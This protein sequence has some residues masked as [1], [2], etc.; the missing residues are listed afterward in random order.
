MSKLSIAKQIPIQ[1]L[2]KRILKKVLSAKRIDYTAKECRNASSKYRLISLLDDTE[3]D[4]TSNSVA[5]NH[6][7]KHEFNLLGSGWLNRNAKKEIELHSK[8][9]DFYKKT[10]KYISDNYQFINWQL[11]I[12]SG[13]EFDVAKQF[14]KQKPD[15]T[16]CIDVKNCWELGRLQHFLQMAFASKGAKNKEE[17]ILEFKNQCLDFIA[18]NPVGMGIQWACT[19]DVGIRVANL[20]LA[21]DFFNEIDETDI[22]DDQFNQMF[23]NSIYQH[24]L[25]IYHHLEKKEGAAGN[26][27]LFNLIG[28]LFVSN[29]L[30]ESE[31]IEQ[32]RILAEYELENE[33][34]K[35]FLNDGGNFEGS[36]TYHCLSTEAMMY[37]TVFMLRNDKKLDQ[38]YIDLLVKA[39]KFIVDVMKP[40]GEMP[41]FGD[42][43]SGRLFIFYQDQD[44]K[45]NLLSSGSL[46][47]GFSGL[48]DGYN[49]DY[50]SHIK[51]N[52]KLII[53]QILRNKKLKIPEFKQ[54]L[55][56]KELYQQPATCNL[57]QITTQ[58]DF[59][60]PINTNNIKWYSYSDFG[61]DLF[62]SD[63]FY[64]AIS[65]ISNKKMHHSWGH[66]HN[67]KLSFE[68]Q[69]GGVD[70]VKD[71]GSYVYSSNPK[72]RNEYRSTKA[73]H[74]IIV[75]G[76]EQNKLKHLFYLEREVKCKL[77]ELQDLSI[78]LQANYYG[79][80]HIRK[81]EIFEDKLI[82]TDWCN[83][84]FTVNINK[85]GKYSPNYG[86]QKTSK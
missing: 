11:D 19:M 55:K 81:F 79:V 35:Q 45:S 8:H 43:D 16:K 86:V 6:Y 18:S 50:F 83:K 38:K 14:D 61:I 56:Y 40:N 82:I 64:L 47:A 37:A 1:V 57:H 58:I 15:K 27:Y 33:F 63:E 66:V 53:E 36:T 42:N 28:L 80:E 41:Q 31:E 39:K 59:P 70:I 10:I 77:L 69:V 68:L 72:A 52:Q 3:I 48:F 34:Y 29:Y 73:H 25:F 51:E 85:F 67:D 84:A 75:E 54:E 60:S 5:I 21:Y 13:F 76:I 30:F 62:K 32:W 23:I 17:L 20:L 2:V 9:Q 74:G 78:T 49:F 44:N 4:K 46:L 12:K 26:H 24:G 71:P 22:L 7:L 65:T